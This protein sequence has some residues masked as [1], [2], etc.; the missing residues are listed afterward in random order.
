MTVIQNQAWR[1]SV[2]IA[3]SLIMVEHE[4]VGCVPR[5]SEG[6]VAAVP[7][8][9]EVNDDGQ[10]DGEIGELITMITKE[11]VLNTTMMMEV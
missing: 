1:G 11:M 3:H 2:T 9:G 10:I 5:L 8:G 6:A 7:V 4:P